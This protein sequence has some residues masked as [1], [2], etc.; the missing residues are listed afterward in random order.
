MGHPALVHEHLEETGAVSQEEMRKKILAL[1][2]AIKEQPK[3][4]TQN[5]IDSLTSHHFA[6][7][8][9]MRSLRIPKGMLLTGKIHLTEHLNVFVSGD[10]SVW[11][12]QGMKRLTE[13]TIIVSKPGIKRVGFANEESVWITVHANP[14]NERDIPKLEEM[15]V[16][17]DFESLD[18]K[19]KQMITGDIV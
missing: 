10:L 19:T 4:L 9:Y 6:P 7:G 13:H 15:L 5:A 17:D 1:E 18:T 3:A 2:C 12:D 16:T 11:T 8:V 14:S